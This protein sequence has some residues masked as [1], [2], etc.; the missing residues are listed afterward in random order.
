MSTLL[1]YES[2]NNLRDL[3]GEVTE[4]GRRIK[5]GK[6]LRSGRLCGMSEEERARL[7]EL[8]DTVIDLRTANERREQPDDPIPG[9][10][11][12]HLPV[13]GDL[14]PGVTREEEAD[15]NI[16]AK[17]L[18]DPEEG[19]KSV[20]N[21]Y[22]SMIYNDY[23]VSQ[24]GRFLR[25]LLEEHERAIL[26]HCTAGKDRAGMAAAIVETLLG[27]PREAVIED[28]LTT[29]IYLEKDILRLIAM[30]K[31]QV[32][33]DDP[34]A[35]ESLRCIFGASREYPVAFFAAA[36][37]RFGSFQGYAEKGLGLTREEIALLREKYTE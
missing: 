16:F 9:A 13:M 33:T 34:R 27:V 17:H 28:Y 6:L 24:Y 30:V 29:N 2:L 26:W 14:N 18:L 23:T 12:I 32:G 1:N 10:V 7:G 19:K 36:E 5:S 25:C 35:D 22:R 37:E 21:L 3:G 15:Q 20:C 8:A 11:S 4:D 31:K